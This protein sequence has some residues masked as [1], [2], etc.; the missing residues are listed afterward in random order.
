MSSYSPGGRVQCWAYKEKGVD[1]FR[2]GNAKRKLQ[3]TTVHAS[4]YGSQNN[5]IK[6]NTFFCS[7]GSS[8]SMP[9]YS[10]SFGPKLH[11]NGELNV[12]IASYSF[13]Y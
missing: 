10:S 12:T 1:C 8:T 9:E 13:V 7:F 6:T 3:T 4:K 11:G 2:G 5:C